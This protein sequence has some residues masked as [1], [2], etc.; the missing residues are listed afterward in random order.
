MASLN[1]I[2]HH[3]YNG[4]IGAIYQ[5]AIWL[6]LTPVDFAHFLN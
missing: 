2:T 3:F 1:I 5:S 6:K 4:K